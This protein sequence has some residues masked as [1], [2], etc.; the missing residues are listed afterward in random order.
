MF[1]DVLVVCVGN[2]CRSPMAEA[3]LRHRLSRPGV[4]LHS[5]GIGAA[6][7]TPMDPL[8]I[9]VLQEH[10]VPVMAHAARRA[11]RE[12]LRQAELIL[13]M[14]RAHLLNIMQ[15]APEVRG[16]AFLIGQWQHKTEIAD[17]FRRPRQAFEQAYEHL[18]RCVD[19]WLPYLQSGETR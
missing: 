11:D 6:P 16:K 19:D 8:A 3:L 10:Q 2:I 5:A 12:L 18:S 1:S 7:G 4:K 15:L 9:E 14:E 17:P 13:L